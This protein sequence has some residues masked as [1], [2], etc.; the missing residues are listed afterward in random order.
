MFPNPH[1]DLLLEGWR[2]TQQVTPGSVLL[3]E[4]GHHEVV[5]GVSLATRHF[6]CFLSGT[7]EAVWLKKRAL[8][9]VRPKGVL[10]LAHY[11]HKFW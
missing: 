4:S 3:G 11:L 8:M 9:G 7:V 10:I 5:L 2:L 6:D 1:T